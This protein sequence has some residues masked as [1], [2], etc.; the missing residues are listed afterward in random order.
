MNYQDNDTLGMYS[1]DSNG[2]GPRTNKGPG[3]ELMGADT[4]LGND[5]YNL[6]GEDIGDIKEIMLDMRDGRVAYAV[7][8]FT[9]FLSMGEKLFAVPWSA[10]TLDT[11]HKRFTLNVDKDRLKDAPGFDKSRWP[12][13]ADQSWQKEIHTYY[14]TS[15]H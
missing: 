14:G 13:M 10:L 15:Q 4:L 7:L 8:A 5:V 3:P 11:E 2:A 9:A 1:T 12:N 6:K